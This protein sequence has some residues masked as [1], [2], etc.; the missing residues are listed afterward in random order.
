MN[1]SSWDFRVQGP[2]RLDGE[3]E[4]YWEKLLAPG[5]VDSA[6]AT[7]RR[8]PAL[9]NR[10]KGKDEKFPVSGYATYSLRLTGITP[11]SP[12]TLA[13]PE[14]RT[15]YRMWLDTA[16]VA[17]NG[18]VATDRAHT[19]PQYLPQTVTVF[20]QGPQ[21]RLTIQV[22]NFHGNE[23]GIPR[24]IIA[25]NQ[26]QLLHR[27][28]A[29]RA[30]NIFVVGALLVIALYYT[31]LY[32]MGKK[33]PVL[34][35]LGALGAIVIAK[36]LV[37][38][39]R[40]LA[41][42]FPHLPW[43]VILKIETIPMYVGVAF[44]T[45]FIFTLYP[46]EVG[47]RTF[48]I[49]FW[50]SL[51]LGTLMALLPTQPMYTVQLV[52]RHFR[53]VAALY[54]MYVLVRAIIAKRD[55]ALIITVGF[56]FQF[57]T[58]VYDSLNEQHVIQS[59]YLVHVGLIIFSLFAGIVIN[60][61]FIK[62]EQDT[63]ERR[64]RL[65]HIEKLAALG[66]VVAGVAHE[67][68][69]PN[70]SLQLDAQTQHKALSTLFGVLDEK[71]PER[72]FT[73]GGYG[74]E[75]LKSDLLSSASRMIRNSQRISRIVSNLRALG[76]KEVPMNEDIDLNATVAAALGVVDYVVK[77]STRSLALDLAPG[78]PIVKGNS[79][80]LEQVVIN[81]VRNAC[82][83]LA[84]IDR[85]VTIVTAFDAANRVVTLT[86]T[87]EGSGMD[88]ETCRKVLTPYFTTKGEEGTGLGLS[89]CKNIVTLHHGSI[90][91]DSEVGKGTAI[92]IALP[93]TPAHV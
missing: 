19:V 53:A 6:P 79:Q 37:V 78:L 84:D 70:N 36:S 16:E 33:E 75:E 85:A 29:H 73:I 65:A 71:L 89:I 93:V 82:Q 91:I 9:W 74:Y 17:S 43:W 28:V 77:R 66:T 41:Q 15:A 5:S 80:Y 3:W 2:V 35:H 44:Y 61:R 88:G 52:A 69:N 13:V 58:L 26:Q 27:T 25:G 34:L 18:V 46:K 50:T 45:N 60:R 31:G 63:R 32:A 8:V 39:D 92:R 7:Y 48:L 81:L 83:S 90:S 76:K 10:A 62:A 67:I 4:F 51:G 68:N 12:L 42:Y 21:A 20:P 55:G 57:G 54:G 59:I 47:R 11:R 23:A 64:D 22:A 72:A 24:S 56:F 86:V 14:M 38:G 30:F 87:D 1:L 49:L 40:L